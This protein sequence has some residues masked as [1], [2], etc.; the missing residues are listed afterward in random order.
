MSVRNSQH[1]GCQFLLAVMFQ[2]KRAVIF[3]VEI[4]QNLTFLTIFSSDEKQMT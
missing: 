3:V 4:R 2:L 1:G